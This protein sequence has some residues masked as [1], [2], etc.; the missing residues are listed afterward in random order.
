MFYKIGL[1]NK[2]VL[3]NLSR[4]RRIELFYKSI[5]LYY[6]HTNITGNFIYFSNNNDEEER[7]TINF[8]TQEEAKRVFRDIELVLK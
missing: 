2:T 6:P 5:Y 3:Y 8:E 4:V 7:M 1:K